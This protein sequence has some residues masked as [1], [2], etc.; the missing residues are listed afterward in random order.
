MRFVELV[1]GEFVEEFPGNESLS[2]GGPV[3]FALK[4]FLV[5]V[6]SEFFVQSGVK[7]GANEL[8]VNVGVDRRHRERCDLGFRLSH[9]ESQDGGFDIGFDVVPLR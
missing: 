3:E 1:I 2:G 6:A 7:Q 8:V 9:L 4:I 5:S